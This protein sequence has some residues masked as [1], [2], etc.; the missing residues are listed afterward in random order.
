[1]GIIIIRLII[2]KEARYNLGFVLNISYLLDPLVIDYIENGIE[3][4]FLEVVSKIKNRDSEKQVR[5]ILL[6]K[7]INVDGINLLT[8]SQTIAYTTANDSDK[9]SLLEIIK[10]IIQT[11]KKK[12][13]L[14]IS[15]IKLHF[16]DL[17]EF[18]F[19]ERLKT[20]IYEF[21][22]DEE[23][24]IT[25][26]PYYGQIDNWDVDAYLFF[27]RVERDH[28][29]PTRSTTKRARESRIKRIKA[30]N[31]ETEVN[32]DTKDQKNTIKERITKKQKLDKGKT[33]EEV[34]VVVPLSSKRKKSSNT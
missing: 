9:V 24:I 1:M 18:I 29:M 12:E 20:A 27:N 28:F 34:N 15:Y 8:I 6:K 32:D 30:D 19:D 31:P 5:E 23:L 16:P 7:G 2:I 4:N 21:V 14:V 17:G 10:K 26:D 13:G 3:E 33:K 11:R 22:N 25:K